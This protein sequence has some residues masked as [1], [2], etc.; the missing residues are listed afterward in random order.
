MVPIAYP[1]R[2]NTALLRT[3]KNPSP[4]KLPLFWPA[5]TVPEGDILASGEEETSIVYP[6]LDPENYNLD[7]PGKCTI[8][9][10]RLKATFRGLLH[11]REFMP[12]AKDLVKSLELGKSWARGE[13]Y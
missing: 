3:Q 13:T 2:Y 6:V 9:A 10:W 5:F 1:S 8:V 4:R 11:G 12:S 7:L